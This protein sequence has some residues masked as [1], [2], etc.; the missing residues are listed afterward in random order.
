MKEEEYELRNI[1]NSI[2]VQLED[3]NHKLHTI[4]DGL[5]TCMAY[6]EDNKEMHE[7]I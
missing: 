7:N 4:E 5:A 2:V 6:V 3:M 1:I